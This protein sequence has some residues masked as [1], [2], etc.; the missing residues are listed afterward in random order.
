MV[1][2]KE[3]KRLADDLAISVVEIE[4]ND[5]EIAVMVNMN[6]AIKP[7]DWEVDYSKFN[8]TFRAKSLSEVYGIIHYQIIPEYAEWI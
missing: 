2:K 7:Y 4:P 5:F 6:P 3:W 1:V 8:D